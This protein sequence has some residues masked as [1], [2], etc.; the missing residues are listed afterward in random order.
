MIMWFKMDLNWLTRC[1]FRV[2]HGSDSDS[3]HRGGAPGNTQ[4]A[5]H[6][7][8]Y[9]MRNTT[10]LLRRP[11]CKKPGKPT[12][13]EQSPT[14]PWP[15]WSH[16]VAFWSCHHPASLSDSYHR[17]SSVH[18]YVLINETHGRIDAYVNN[19]HNRANT[20][21]V[22]ILVTLW[23]VK[24]NN[25]YRKFRSETKFYY[26]SKW[27]R[28]YSRYDRYQKCCVRKLWDQ[29]RRI[30]NCYTRVL[31]GVGNLESWPKLF[32]KIYYWSK[33]KRRN[34]SRCNRYQKCCVRKLWDQLLNIYNCYIHTC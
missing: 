21:L 9:G 16:S 25:R 31:S 20:N 15:W 27:K 18:M 19:T 13:L 5:A 12:C 23:L 33:W 22:T 30:Y 8:A 11:W 4:A 14:W 32:R 3:E 7:Y 24:V 10:R 29:L 2:N 26:W 34:Y 17:I 28:S 6:M 1:P